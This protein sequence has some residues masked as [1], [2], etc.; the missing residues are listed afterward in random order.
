MFDCIILMHTN[1]NPKASDLKS[2]TRLATAIVDLSYESRDYDLLNLNIK[3]LEKKHGQLKAVIQ[4]I[5]EQSMAW[6]DEIKS[7]AGTSR[8]LQLIDT[9]RSVTEGKVRKVIMWLNSAG[10]THLIDFPR[11]TAGQGHSPF[12]SSY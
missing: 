9:L 6:L 7:S 12:V 11:N 8:W 3:T 4:S 10:V 2:T 5:V 1:K